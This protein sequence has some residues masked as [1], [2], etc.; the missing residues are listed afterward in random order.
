MIKQPK[1]MAHFYCF[2]SINF[3]FDRGFGL[4]LYKQLLPWMKMCY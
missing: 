2:F 4:K 3:F 1:T